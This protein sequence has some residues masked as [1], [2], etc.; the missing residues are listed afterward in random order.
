MSGKLFRLSLTVAFKAPSRRRYNL[1]IIGH[2][3]HAGRLERGFL[4]A[5]FLFDGIDNPVQVDDAIRRSISM[6]VESTPGSAANWVFTSE[7]MLRSV[8]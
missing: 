7:A 2:S 6:R 8:K 4:R 1:Q 5:R 3:A